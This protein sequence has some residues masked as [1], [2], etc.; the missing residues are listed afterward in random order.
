ML[1]ERTAQFMCSPLGFFMPRGELFVRSFAPVATIK[2]TE[3]ALP[4]HEQIVW[5]AKAIAKYLGR[6]EK[7]TWAALEQKKVPGARK[8]A[9]RW[10]LSLKVFFATFD[11]AA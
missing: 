4:A 8:V 1:A 11:A 10:A 2:N 6:S 5:G 9:G 3:T 7:A